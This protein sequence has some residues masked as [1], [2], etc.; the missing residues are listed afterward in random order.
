MARCTD[1]PLLLPADGLDPFYGFKFI[2][3]STA[4]P[5][6]SSY[7]STAHQFVY[8]TNPDGSLAHTYTWGSNTWGLFSGYWQRD[9]DSATNTAARTLISTGGGQRI[10][11]DSSLDP[12]IDQ[13]YQIVKSDPP[14]L[15]GDI[16]P[17]R[18]DCQGEAQRLVGIA[19]DLQKQFMQSRFA[20]NDQNGNPV[21]NAPAVPGSST[22]GG[23]ISGW[24][25]SLFTSIGD[26]FSS[27]QAIAAPGIEPAFGG[28]HMPAPSLDT[29]IQP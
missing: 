3:T 15:N 22:S 26:F 13:A 5:W 10:G 7:A 28:P 27:N 11:P 1:R 6:N 25:G 17:T 2:A 20:Y 14:H 19:Q 18:S 29:I 9:T 24:I 16:W 8:T 4:V 21:Y 12:F 23:S